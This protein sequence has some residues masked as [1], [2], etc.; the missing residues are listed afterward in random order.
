MVPYTFASPI[1]SREQSSVPAQPSVPAQSSVPEAFHPSRQNQSP[2]FDSHRRDGVGPV[3]R[4]TDSNPA[5]LRCR[6]HEVEFLDVL[7]NTRD[8]PLPTVP[9]TGGRGSRP[10]GQTNRTDRE[11]GDELLTCEGLMESQKFLRKMKSR[12]IKTRSHAV[13]V[14]VF[15][16]CKSGCCLDL[17]VL[18]LESARQEYVNT[19]TVTKRREYLVKLLRN[20]EELGRPMQVTQCT[21][22]GKLL[23]LLCIK[24]IFNVSMFV[25]VVQVRS[26]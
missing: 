4:R 19:G 8:E 14:E 7:E 26:L 10:H 13:P 6:L 24:A 25:G 17:C 12:L 23:C 22:R 11:K 2:A 1:Y 21:L 5:G 18:W 20:Q 3:P 16:K 9:T 15:H